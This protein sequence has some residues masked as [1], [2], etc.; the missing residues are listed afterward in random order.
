MYNLPR[1]F[2]KLRSIDKIITKKLRD[3]DDTRIT[4]RDNET[5]NAYTRFENSNPGGNHRAN[6]F[7]R[8]LARVY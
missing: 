5:R 1:R 7:G 8:I 6:D 4:G 3:D 2:R